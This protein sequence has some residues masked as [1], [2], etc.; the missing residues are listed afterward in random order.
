[1]AL[2][3]P[4]RCKMQ[5]KILKIIFLSPDCNVSISQFTVS[6]YL[7]YIFF[8]SNNNNQEQYVVQKNVYK[9]LTAYIHELR[10][11]RTKGIINNNNVQTKG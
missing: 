6:T 5:K 9:T 7:L 11:K 2:E 3:N 4:Q 1:M 10:E 8:Y